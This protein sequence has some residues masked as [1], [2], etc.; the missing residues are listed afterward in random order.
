LTRRLAAGFA[1]LAAATWLLIIAGGL[2]RA[3]GA[4]LACPDWP[5]CFGELVPRF[6]ARIALEWGHRLIAGAVT[7]GLAALSWAALRA[8]RLGRHLALLWGLLG[9]QIVLGGLTVLLQ[10][11]PWTVTVHLVVGN[12]FCA[13]LLW[14]AADLRERGLRNARSPVSGALR[15]AV[16]AAVGLVALQIVLGG[17]VSSHA[18]GLACASFPTCDGRSLVPTLHGPVGIHVLHRLNGFAL[19]A[20]LAWLV[21]ASR[22][23]ALLGRLARGATR[24][25][26]IQILIGVLNVALRLPVEITAAHTAI[27]AAIVLIAGAMLREVVLAGSERYARAPRRTAEA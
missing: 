9:V 7:L 14:T 24:L 10:L 13:A 19:L 25:V 17:L 6:D 22:H 1:A 11:A 27:A 20:V 12:S 3:H 5:L 2:V 18:A 15:V 16:I 21:W 8:G 26:L 23:E 4:G